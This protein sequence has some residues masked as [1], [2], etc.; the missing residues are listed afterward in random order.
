LFGSTIDLLLGREFVPISVPPKLPTEDSRKSW[1]AGAFLHLKQTIARLRQYILGHSE[2]GV[3][4]RDVEALELSDW[5]EVVRDQ[6]RSLKRQQRAMRKL[7][8]APPFDIETT[9]PDR[10]ATP[11]EVVYENE[12]ISRIEK[13][14]APEERPYWEALLA[15]ERPRHVA[16]RLGIDRKLASKKMKK[17]EAKVISTVFARPDS[18]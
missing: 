9:V 16:A 7:V 8:Y 10:S 13:N 4:A 15:G 5:I 6:G 1:E 17:L 2:L 11:F 14:L 18:A 12:I 3:S